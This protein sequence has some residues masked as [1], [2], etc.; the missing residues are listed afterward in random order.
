MGM[1]GNNSSR[2]RDLC[3]TAFRLCYLNFYSQ[4]T[5][6]ATEYMETPGHIY[7][8][9][10]ETIVLSFMLFKSTANLEKKKNYAVSLA[11]SRSH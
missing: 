10:K 8:N 11:D 6:Q 7:L 1:V 9:F 2:K 4:V 5:S 3:S